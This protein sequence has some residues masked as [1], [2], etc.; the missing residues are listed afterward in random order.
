MPVIYGSYIRWLYIPVIYLGY[1]VMSQ[2][3]EHFLFGDFPENVH[4]FGTASSEIF[5]KMFIILGQKSVH[6]FGTK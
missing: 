2:N 4:Y 3:N 1:T 5:Q 6:Y